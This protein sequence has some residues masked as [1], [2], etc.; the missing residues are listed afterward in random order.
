MTA[1][2][3]GNVATNAGGMNAVKYGVTRHN[4]LGLEAVLLNGEIPVANSDRFQIAVRRGNKKV[5]DATGG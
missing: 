4:V 5:L 3:G 2:I 1:T